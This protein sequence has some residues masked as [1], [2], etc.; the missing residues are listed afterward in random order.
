[1]I[2]PEFVTGYLQCLLSEIKMTNIDIGHCETYYEINIRQHKFGPDSI[3]KHVQKNN[4]RPP[5]TVKGLT[6]V[7]SCD[8]TEETI[9]KQGLNEALRLFCLSFKKRE[10]NLVG[11]LILDHIK[12]HAEGLY[13]YLM[14]DK[15]CHD[16]F[17]NKITNDM[18]KA[19]C[20]FDVM[21]NNCLNHWMVDYDIICVLKF[22]GYSSWA[23]VTTKQRELCFKDYNTNF[24]LPLWNIGKERYH[25]PNGVVMHDI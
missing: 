7:Y 25:G 8:T 12:N 14:R 4:G 5:Q 23:D 17:A 22:C 6:F 2:K 20:S 11:P 24:N 1:L 18:N 10:S 19:F 21:W 3:W 15:P 13:K 9:G 16:E